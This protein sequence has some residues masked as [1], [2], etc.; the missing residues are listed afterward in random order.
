MKL[1][2]RTLR[3]TRATGRTATAVLL[4]A[5]LALAS[6]SEATTIIDIDARINTTTNPV[7]HFF[8]A[9]TYDVTPIGVAAGG[10]YDAWNAWGFVAG[11]DSNG[12]NCSNGWINSYSLSAPGLGVPAQTFS[13]GGRYATPLQALNAA[14]STQFTIATSGT[15]NFFITDN[16]YTDNLGGMSLHVTSQPIPEPSTV[17]LFSTGMVG[18]IGFARRRRRSA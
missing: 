18:L 17:L 1:P 14:I 2:R 8:A 13:D 11:C 16:P 7:T 15:V 5:G 4:V 3:R 12:E 6:R 10:A 9:G